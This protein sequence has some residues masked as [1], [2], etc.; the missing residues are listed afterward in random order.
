MFTSLRYPSPK[1]NWIWSQR[2]QNKKPSDIADAL[3]VSRPFVSKEQRIAEARIKKLIHHA[4][5]INRIT[6]HK[7]SSRYGIAIGYCSTFQTNTYILY[8]P[9]IG[10]QTWF[11]HKGECDGCSD[12]PQCESTLS[13]L[14]QEWNIPIPPQMVPTDLAIYLFDTIIR[15]LKWHDTKKRGGK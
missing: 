2:R 10:L 5:S 15:R 7:L 11:A 12:Y 4:A 8:S 6:I 1:Q 14:A 3:K 9:S 13:T